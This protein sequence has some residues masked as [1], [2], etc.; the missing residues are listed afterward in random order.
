M[1]AFHF[2]TLELHFGHLSAAS[3]KVAG[4]IEMYFPKVNQKVGKYKTSR[5]WFQNILEQSVGHDVDVEAQLSQQ[6]Q[7]VIGEA[8]CEL[9]K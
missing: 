9:L 4:D 5:S 7:D 2:E 1:L 8:C 3:T 6:N